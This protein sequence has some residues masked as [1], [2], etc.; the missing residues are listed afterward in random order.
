MEV[1]MQVNSINAIGP[2]NLS[3]PLADVFAD[4]PTLPVGAGSTAET[5]Q[6]GRE[7]GAGSQIFEQ[8]PS[9]PPNVEDALHTLEKA[10]EG[11]NIALNFSRDDETGSIVVKLVDQTSGEIV[12]QIPSEALLHLSASLGKL[13]GK[14]FN[15]KA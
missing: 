9:Q 5:A 13:Q 12:Q 8:D 2:I 10:V 11:S 4:A 14:V 6:A 1:Y 7:S 15:Q 3:S